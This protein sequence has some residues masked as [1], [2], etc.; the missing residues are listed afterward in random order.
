MDKLQQLINNYVLEPRKELNNFNLAHKYHEMGQTASALSHYLREAELT[1]NKHLAYECLLRAGKCLA[2]QGKRRKSE[3][4]LYLQA[5]DLLPE[6]PEVYFLLS[7]YHEKERDWLEA[8]VMANL[9]LA[10]VSNNEPK[11]NT[12]SIGYEGE[13]VLWFQKAAA[14]WWTSKMD[15]SRELFQFIKSEYKNELNDFYK[16]LV[17]KN[18]SD[19]GSGRDIYF[20]YTKE[21][22]SK[23]KYK[24]PGS[25]TIEKV[26]GQSAQ[27]LFVLT[28]LNGKTNGSYLEIGAADPYLGNN[29]VLLEEKFR[30]KGLSIDIDKEEV[31]KF[32]TKRDNP[33]IQ[34]DALKV[35]YSN[36]L[37]EYKFNKDVDYL[38]LDCEPPST[39]FEI[40]RKIPFDQYRFAVITFEHDFYADI[41]EKYR[42]LSRKYL[43]A[44]GYKLIA[45]NVSHIQDKVNFNTSFEDWWV[46]PDLVEEEIIK[47]FNKPNQ[48]V[49]YTKEYLFNNLK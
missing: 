48:E 11:L 18:I 47:K 10:R 49:L 36:L 39:T 4:G 3:R 7:Q 25:E 34:K 27:D 15:E 21:L 37:K 8:Y 24:F 20:K 26:Y 9:G 1:K 41:E 14:A 31:D 28:M 32:K 44:R 30:W 5:L 2:S 35:D 12:F 22:H 42:D 17:Q 45:G 16:N 29:T 40:L 46:H 23:L 38:Q 33:I 43:Q 6:R 13:Y 19:L